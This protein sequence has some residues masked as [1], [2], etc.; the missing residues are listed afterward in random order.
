MPRIMKDVLSRVFNEK[1]F[2]VESKKPGV[3]YCVDSLSK[4]MRRLLIFDL[5][6]LKELKQDSF[7]SDFDEL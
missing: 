2:V 4:F 3:S 6:Y 5:L 1:I 7:R